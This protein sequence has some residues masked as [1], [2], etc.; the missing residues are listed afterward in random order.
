MSTLAALPFRNA[1][2]DNDSVVSALR[3]EGQ[4]MTAPV[5]TIAIPTFNRPELVRETIASA[6]A[7]TFDLPTEI[8]IID[9]ASDQENTQSLLDHVRSLGTYPIRYYV[10]EANIGM[11]GNWNRC[12]TLARGKWLTILSDDDLLLPDH[13]RQIFSE[14]G[15]AGPSRTSYTCGFKFL[16]QRRVKTRSPILTDLFMKLKKILRFGGRRSVVLT[17]RR[18]FWSNIAGSALGAVFPRDLAIEIGGFYPEDFPSADYFFHARISL[19]GKL[20]QISRDLA[21]MRLQVNETMNPKTLLGFID[22]NHR[23]RIGLINTTAV[24][25]SWLAISPVLIAYERRAALRFTGVSLSREEV[26]AATNVR[27]RHFPSVVIWLWRAL[28]GGL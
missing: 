3:Y 13:L 25:R 18:L 23:L 20:V 17:P 27:E 4:T 1:L 12:I 5:V 6:I 28:H 15:D 24:P 21:L 19:K 14:I 11:F 26:A 2:N 16:D 8:L 10:N 22:A 9:N 7:Q